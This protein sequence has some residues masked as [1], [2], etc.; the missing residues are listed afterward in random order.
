[1]TG[2]K[3]R[4]SL[5][6]LFTLLLVGLLG[7]LIYQ[8][9]LLPGQ[10]FVLHREFGIRIPEGYLIHGIDVSHH[11]GKISWK[12]VR[13]MNVDG[14]KI[15]FAIIKATEG[16]NWTDRQFKR[17]WTETRKHSI[18]RG[19]YHFFIPGRSGISQANRFIRTVKLLPGDLPPV[20]DIE[21]SY[22][23]SENTVRTGVSQWLARVE[24]YYKIKPIIYTN[25]S[26]YRKFLKGHFDEYP[27][28]IA[29]YRLKTKPRIEPWLMWQHSETGKV[30]GI[31][32]KVDFNVF[33]GDSI[34]FRN[35]LIQ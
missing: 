27:L 25:P 10:Q 6:Y 34:A 24:S 35:L 32:T 1:M 20:L 7:I 21:E 12:H 13:D 14:I 26:F 30:N 18:P 11:Q 3:K 23:A 2:K 29:H 15:G 4:R 31:N 17:N 28:W 19:A 9:E 22:G 33:S 5:Y 8:L 16:E